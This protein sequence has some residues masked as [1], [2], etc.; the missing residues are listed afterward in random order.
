MPF[1]NVSL[2]GMLCIKGFEFETLRSSQVKAVASYSA[3]DF[4]VCLSCPAFIDHKHTKTC[5]YNTPKLTHTIVSNDACS[6]GEIYS[7]IGKVFVF[8]ILC[9][10]RIPFDRQ[11]TVIDYF[12]HTQL[13]YL[14]LFVQGCTTF[15]LF[16]AASRLFL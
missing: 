16:Q 10:E 11:L 7:L 1:G 4:D 2:H 5:H 12:H 13:L 9:W 15:L 14:F 3:L 6:M 8:E